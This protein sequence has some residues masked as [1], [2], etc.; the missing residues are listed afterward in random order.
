[1]NRAV[2]LRGGRWL[3]AAVL[4]VLLA[5]AA[6]ALT[7]YAMA[8]QPGVDVAAYLQAGERLRAGEP[9][10]A[11]SAAN[12]S[13]QF[14]YAPW[15]AYAWVPLT[16]L[17]HDA[18]VAGWVGLMLAAAAASVV[19]LL[20]HGWTGVAAFAILAPLQ[21]QGAVFGNVQ[22]LLVLILMWGVEKRSGPWWVALGASLK[23]VPLL[24]AVVYAGRGEWRRVAITLGFT[25]LLA[26]PA[27]LFDLSGYSTDPG[28]AQISLAGV[29]FP[30]YLL[31]ALAA[32]A[33]CWFL[34]RTRYGWLAG[35]FAM[36]AGLPRLLTYE[37]GFLLVGL[38]NAPPGR[39]RAG[40]GGGGVVSELTGRSSGAPTMR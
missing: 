33:A 34:A 31:V 22:P 10:Y 32:I 1:M 19:P 6:Y 11:V 36:I 12:A 4:A 30:A 14:R 5:L 16:F 2:L 15:F 37:L 8:Q 20:R 40:G 23:A 3:L 26:G 24:L 27:L 21:L 29:W 7:T 25:A 39:S 35:A 18:V 17:D 13:E 38:Q 9:L 28:P